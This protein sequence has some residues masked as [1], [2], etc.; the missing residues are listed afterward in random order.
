MVFLLVSRWLPAWSLSRG[1][2]MLLKFFSGLCSIYLASPK[3]EPLLLLVWGDPWSWCSLKD[4]ALWDYSRRWFPLFGFEVDS[5]ADP[6][7]SIVSFDPQDA[8]PW[9]VFNF[10]AK[11]LP[12]FYEVCGLSCKMCCLAHRFCDF[13]PLLSSGKSL[14][15]ALGMLSLYSSSWY[16]EPIMFRV[17]LLF[18]I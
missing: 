17:G 6:F 4:C 9:G 14:Q 7:H 1:P 18:A 12:F 13:Y 3:E 10:L 2:F 11:R 15:V 5:C 8:L 16:F